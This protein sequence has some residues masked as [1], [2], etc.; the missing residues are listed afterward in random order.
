AALAES[1]LS[2][3]NSP[4]LINSTAASLNMLHVGHDDVSSTVEQVNSNGS[5]SPGLSPQQ[6]GHQIHVK[7]E[8]AEL[9]EDSRPMSLIAS[10]TQNLS[11]PGD[12]RDMEE[13]LPTEELE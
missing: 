12:D 10:V 6:Y 7:E 9:E 5:C 3:L 13:E 1:N 8:P 2:L 11:M 4:T